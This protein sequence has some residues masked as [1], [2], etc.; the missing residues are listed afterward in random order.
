MTSYA[1]N[2]FILMLY[3]K[4]FFMLIVIYNYFSGYCSSLGKRAAN[5]DEPCIK[6]KKAASSSI[7]PGAQLFVCKS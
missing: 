1:I 4:S 3:G 2:F 5:W 7:C 6:L